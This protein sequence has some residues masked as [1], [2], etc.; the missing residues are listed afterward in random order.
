MAVRN[1]ELVQFILSSLPKAET[2]LASV[3]IR[4]TE[5]I[6]GRIYCLPLSTTQGG[7]NIAGLW[8]KSPSYK[9]NRSDMQQAL[10]LLLRARYSSMFN[11]RLAHTTIKWLV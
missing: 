5:R 6:P 3:V 2:P 10:S 4:N 1:L 7:T 11:R 8:S 9:I